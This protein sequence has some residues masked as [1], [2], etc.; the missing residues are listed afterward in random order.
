MNLHTSMLGGAAGVVMLAG[1]A[2][3]QDSYYDTNPTPEERAQTER[4]NTDAANRAQSAVDS[5][6]AANASYHAELDAYERN[7]AAYDAERAAYE[8]ERAGYEANR[9]GYAHRWETFYGYS[10]FHSVDRMRSGALLG[11]AVSTRGGSRVGRIRDVDVG[12]DGRI[13]RVS[14]SVG[15]GRTAWIDVDDLR[16][17]PAARV[18]LTDLSRGQIDDMARMRYPRF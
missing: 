2:L 6:A 9:G 5:S 12:D 3:A 4:L 11:L 18:V 7:R 8:R 10:R 1:S 17:D 14:V 13:S 16:Y 15:A